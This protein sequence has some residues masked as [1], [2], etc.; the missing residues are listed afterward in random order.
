MVA[1]LFPWEN[2]FN[3]F[4]IFLFYKLFHIKTQAL[5]ILSQLIANEFNKFTYAIL[6]CKL[7]FVIPLFILFYLHKFN[8][9]IVLNSETLI[10]LPIFITDLKPDTVKKW[11]KIIIPSLWAL[12]EV[13]SLHLRDIGNF[14]WDSYDVVSKIMSYIFLYLCFQF[15]ATIVIL[16]SIHIFM[17]VSNIHF[18]WKVFYSDLYLVSL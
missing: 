15:L 4:Y 1:L 10:K 2:I 6:F 3:N 14:I 5:L 16:A 17:S 8:I 11:V 12:L 9:Y 18:L 7:Y 13:S